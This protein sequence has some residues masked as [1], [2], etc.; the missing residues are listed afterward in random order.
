[1]IAPFFGLGGLLV[2]DG[3]K[4]LLMIEPG[5]PF[6]GARNRNPLSP[7]ISKNAPGIQLDLRTK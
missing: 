1:L 5:Y 2:I 3:F 4:Q 6:Q 7:V